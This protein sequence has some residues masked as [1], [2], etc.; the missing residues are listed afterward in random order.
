GGGEDA[1]K[2]ERRHHGN[3]GEG[4]VHNVNCK[5]RGKRTPPLRHDSA[6]QQKR[7]TGACSR[8]GDRTRSRPSTAGSVGKTRKSSRA[9]TPH[10]SLHRAFGGPGKQ[11]GI[12]DGV[13]LDRASK[14]AMFPWAY[15]GRGQDKGKL[16]QG[17]SILRRTHCTR[18]ADKNGERRLPLQKVDVYTLSLR[19]VRSR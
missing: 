9:A 8:R 17:Q 4:A 18:V 16:F 14:W 13:Y 11:V 5:R 19:L 6:F 15:P 1:K 3:G 10:G 12:P 2:G 7:G